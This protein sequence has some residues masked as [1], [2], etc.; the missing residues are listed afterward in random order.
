MSVIRQKGK[1]QDGCFKNTKH[2]KFSKKRAFLTS[3]TLTKTGVSRK[4][5]TPN[6][7]AYQGVR[8]VRFSENLACFI[9]LKHPFG[10]STFSLITDELLGLFRQNDKIK[11]FYS[12]HHSRPL[13]FLGFLLITFSKLDQITEDV[14]INAK[15]F[16]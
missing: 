13:S 2:A 14:I 16:K 11:W 8:N 9:F 10:D 6:S 5:S 12:L 1:S 4:Q 7:C 3:D 15:K